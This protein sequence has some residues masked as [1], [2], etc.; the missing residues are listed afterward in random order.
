MSS[1][2]CSPLVND[3]SILV[4]YCEFSTFNCIASQCISLSHL[5]LCIK[6]VDF[7]VNLFFCN[8]ECDFVSSYISFRSSL[9]DKSVSLAF[10]K[11][12]Y[13]MFLFTRYPRINSISICILDSKSSTRNFLSACDIC[14]SD[15]NLLIKH[16][17]FLV[18]LILRYSEFDR[19]SFYIAVWGSCFC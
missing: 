1:A 4:E 17:Y 18:H 16:V 3:I 2:V 19:F 9:F 6:H 8:S 10:F 11:S 14:L 5:H 12:A 13:I 7:L 15:R